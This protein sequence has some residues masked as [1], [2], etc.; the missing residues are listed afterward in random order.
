[1]EQQNNIT[2][3]AIHQLKTYCKTLTKFNN[4]AFGYK[5]KQ[6]QVLSP[7]LPFDFCKEG[8]KNGLELDGISKF[9]F[10]IDQNINTYIFPIENLK[11]NKVELIIVPTADLISRMCD[12]NTTND[13]DLN[14]RFWITDKAIFETQGI[15]A[16]YEFLGL[17]LNENR[18]YNSYRN[19][20]SILD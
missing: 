9:N 8:S 4:G 16:E 11:T 7:S 19:N 2:Q 17:W 15:G 12:L 5:G 3:N 13:K 20:L 6:I 10:T 18:C 1:M 14:I